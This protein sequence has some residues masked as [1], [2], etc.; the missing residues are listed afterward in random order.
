MASGLTVAVV[1]APGVAKELAKKSTQSDITLYHQVT[2]GHAL[3]VV[4]PTQYPEKF[5]PLLYALA[6][7]D[8]A[9]LAVTGLDRTIAETAATLDLFDLPVEIRLGPSVGEEEI[10]KAFRGLRLQQAPAAPLDLLKLRSELLEWRAPSREGPVIVGIDHYFPVKGVG[11][12]ALGFV[13]Q[14]TLV[15]HS[16]LRLY[17]SGKAVELRS[18]QV[19]D[20][21]VKEATAGER[22]G[23]ALKGAEVDELARGQLLAAE[24]TLTVGTTLE[25]SRGRTCPYYRG[26][27]R[28]GAQ[29]H[30]LVGAYLVPASVT[31]REGDRLTVTTDRP[32]AWAAGQSFVLSDLSAP[33]GPRCVGA[34]TL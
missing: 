27:L 6:L 19:H 24:G 25:G 29:L 14:G 12:V 15:A 2:D 20:V 18:I 10:R 33:Q 9:I 13:R 31:S 28:P 3:S 11:T 26:D 5:P 30:A 34:W 21:D 7:S 23:L 8:R 32:V 16:S 22:V 1:G 17:P 4:E